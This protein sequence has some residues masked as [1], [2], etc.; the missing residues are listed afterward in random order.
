MKKICLKQFNNLHNEIEWIHSQTS[1]ILLL[2]SHFCK[3]LQSSQV[4][5]HESG[6]GNDS[7]ENVKY[8]KIITTGNSV[9]VQ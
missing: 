9:K 7:F 6:R 1:L 3:T 8:P 2:S 5:F 4:M